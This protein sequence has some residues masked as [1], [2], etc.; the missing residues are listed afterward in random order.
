MTDQTIEGLQAHYGP[1]YRWLATATAITGTIALALSSTMINVAI[2][3]VMGAFGVGQVQAQW[4]S[5]GFLAAMTGFMLLN[6]WM[7][8]N[9]G[10][11]ATY[12]FAMALFV[13]GSILGGFSPDIETLILGR[14]MQGAAA[15]LSQ[16]LAMLIIFRVFPPEKRG[17]AM[18]IFAVGVVLAPAIGPTVGGMMIDSVNWRYVLFL[19]IP[20]CVLGSLM[21]AAFMPVRGRSGPRT[22]FDWIGFSL[23]FLALATLLTGLSNG[24]RVGWYSNQ[25]YAYLGVALAGGAAF[26]AW[27]LSTRAPMLDLRLFTDRNFAAGSAVGFVFGAAIFG[28]FYLV[29]LFVQTVQG[30]SA[31]RAGMVLMPGGF[32]MLLAFPIAGRLADRMNVFIPMAGGL[33]CFA[34]SSYLMTDV[35][36]NTTFWMVAWWVLLSRLGLSFIMPGLTVGSL[37][38]LPPDLLSQGAGAVNFV[39]QLGGAFGV[40]LLAV[41]LERR[42]ALYSDAFASAQT[43]ANPATAEMV[44]ETVGALTQ[45]GA[46]ETLRLPE[47]MFYLGRMIYTQ[48]SMIGFRD[49]F[50]AVAV[51]TS[52]AILPA[53]VLGRRGRTDATAV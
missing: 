24:Q 34:W 44:R 4:L 50:L 5:T 2:P 37:R 53:Y 36:L 16:P 42:T 27:E 14:V 13:A 25:T 7:V 12:I 10:A 49:A 51:V 23:L 20:F 40:N 32:I 18:G 33:L 15:G 1:A 45:A 8:E 30:Y 31:T 17:A 47:A 21:A 35:D 28:S 19:V 46:P 41:F 11:R 38:T 52:L 29:P 6:A 9:F 43:P 48:A 39:R 26:L 22:G 3:D